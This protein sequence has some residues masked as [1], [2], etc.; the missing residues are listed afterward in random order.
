MKLK[1]FFAALILGAMTMSCQQNNLD[2]SSS[3]DF[4]D[5]VLSAAR[6]SVAEDSTTKRHCKGK[7][8]ELA[9]ADIPAPVTAYINTNYAGATIKYAGTDENGNVVVGLTLT[10]DTRKGLI[11]DSAG[12]FVKELSHYKKRAKLTEVAVADLPASVSAYVVSNYFGAE[13]KRAGTNE[14]GEFFVLLATA[15]KPVVLLFNA[16][17]TFNKVLEK[18]DRKRKHGHK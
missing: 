12:N 9:D 13:I 8:T 1:V 14:A 17:G 16:D 6:F 3:S 4:E 18:S 15:D 2:P 7:L 5:V 10:D 11:F